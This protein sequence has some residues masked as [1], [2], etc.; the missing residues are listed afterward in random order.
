MNVA[1]EKLDNVRGKLTV[2]IEEN[3]YADKV[4]AQL[5]E[6]RKSQAVPGFR[7][8][9]APASM[10]EKKYGEAVKYD[11]V[12]KE[13][14]N[15][16]FGYIRENKLHVL[17]N[18]VP[19]E[20]NR[21]N[22][23]DKDYEME[24][25]VGLAPEFDTH[26]N[27][28][29]HVP[30][31]TIE[32]SEEMINT[33]DMNMR[34]RLGKQEPGEVA[35][36]TAV[37]KGVITELDENGQ[38]KAEGIVVEN[39][40]VSPSY[41]RSE[42][43]K[44]LFEACKPGDVIRFNPAATCDTN[45]AEMSSMLNIDKEDIE[46]HKGDFNFE[47]KE[48]IVLKPAELNEEY[49][50]QVFGSESEIKTEEE[51]RQALKNMIANALMSDSNYRF[52][53]DAREA[54][55]KAVGELELPDEILKDFLRSQ[56]EALNEANIDAEYASA[57]PALEWELI[58]DAV[59]EQLDVKVENEDVLNTARMMARQQFAQYGMTNMGDDIVDKY[60]HDILKDKKAAESIYNQTRDM[61]LFGAIKEAVSCD[62]K[63]VTVE[64]FNALFTPA[65]LS[66]EG[67]EEAKE[68]DHE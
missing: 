3:D 13:I 63:N 40:I 16:L 28:E 55:Q 2:K 60:A 39:G 25:T 68:M 43:Q 5:K 18:P 45:P 56:N 51:Y 41:F 50:K 12:N 8:G 67:A 26:V 47:V 35:D 53:I 4:K 42:E 27:K 66:A 22:L 29:L 1:Y 32:V 9:K 7:P 36:D 64:E 31:Y 21:F 57:R 54:I 49:Y 65:D 37:I 17:G 52:T 33:Q 24:F 14:G 44:K 59:A 6:I 15:A 19:A 62:D 46:N 34:R 11:I 30:Y 20:S 48:V 61:K 10:I 38:P 58:R 23:E